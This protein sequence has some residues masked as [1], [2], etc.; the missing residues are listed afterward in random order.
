VQ[1]QGVPATQLGYHQ[2]VVDGRQAK[3][4]AERTHF[5]VQVSG[6][7]TANLQGPRYGG[8]VTLSPAVC[9]SGVVR[10]TAKPR[11][12]TVSISDLPAGVK[13]GDVLVRCVSGCTRRDFADAFAVTVAGGEEG[14]HQVEAELKFSTKDAA[15]QSEGTYI[16]Q[17]GRNVIEARLGRVGE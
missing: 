3:W 4:D 10:L 16:L 2:L 11:P 8:R 12:A 9:R 1:I 6:D 5:A 17:A 13:A 15:W 7:V 14:E